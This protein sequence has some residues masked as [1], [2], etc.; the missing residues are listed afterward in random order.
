VMSLPWASSVE[1]IDELSGKWSIRE[2][3]AQVLHKS[4]LEPLRNI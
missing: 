3:Y 1:T 2:D 4:F